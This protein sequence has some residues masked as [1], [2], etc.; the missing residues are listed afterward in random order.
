MTPQSQKWTTATSFYSRPTWGAP[1]VTA[2]LLSLSCRCSRASTPYRRR[3]R[4]RALSFFRFSRSLIESP[5]GPVS[6][7]L[8]V[9]EKPN[10]YWG[11]WDH[12]LIK[13]CNLPLIST[14]TKSFMLHF[15]VVQVSTLLLL[16]QVLQAFELV[17]IQRL[18][19]DEFFSS[20]KCHFLC[21]V[22][23][24]MSAITEGK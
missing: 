4:R 15:A 8:P 5:S 23:S 12:T 18:K 1:S 24:C 3:Y 16:Q 2:C 9:I 21:C 20:N 13:V 10:N 22:Y 19:P 6:R 17:N 14:F 11:L 7:P